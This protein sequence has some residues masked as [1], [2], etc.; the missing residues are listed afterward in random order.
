MVYG[1]LVTLG[2]AR[3]GWWRVCCASASLS[4]C[5]V[6]AIPSLDLKLLSLQWHCMAIKAA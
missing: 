3:A 1:S 5:K 2:E 4:C 6:N